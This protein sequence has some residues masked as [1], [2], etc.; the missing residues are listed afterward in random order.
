MIGVWFFITVAVCHY[1]ICSQTNHCRC[2]AQTI[3][4]PLG[5]V[6]QKKLFP[7]GDCNFDVGVQHADAGV[8]VGL[9]R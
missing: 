6:L 4:L 8:L 3:L 7:T 2:T 5:V 9:L 1:F